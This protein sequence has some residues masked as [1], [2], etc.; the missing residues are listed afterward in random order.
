[1]QANCYYKS[2]DQRTPLLFRLRVRISDLFLNIQKPATVYFETSFGKTVVSSKHMKLTEGK[3]MFGIL[4][5]IDVPVKVLFDKRTLRFECQK[6]ERVVVALMNHHNTYVRK[7][8]SIS[9]NIAEILNNELTYVC[10]EF[11][12]ENCTIDKAASVKLGL[13]LDLVG[14]DGKKGRDSIFDGS[15]HSTQSNKD[16]PI[17]DLTKFNFLKQKW[18]CLLISA[19]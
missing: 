10:K 14:H 8:G 12:I 2:I 17:I 9:I 1:M 13:S 5:K 16:I 3:E 19:F 7:L 4:D 11:R 6:K 18:K 15:E